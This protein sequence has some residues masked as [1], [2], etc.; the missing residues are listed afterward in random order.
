MKES[1]SVSETK[2]KIFW[3]NTGIFLNNKN[4]VIERD[5]LRWPGEERNV[6]W[7]P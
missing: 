5:L 1:G 7:L 4:Q 3:P 6:R 2:K